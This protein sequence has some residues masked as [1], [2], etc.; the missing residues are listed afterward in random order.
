MHPRSKIR[1]LI[2]YVIVRA[3]DRCDVL[4]T[5]AMTSTDNC[6]TDHRLIRSIMSIHLMRKQRM[7]K[8]Q[9]RPKLNIEQ[10]GDITYQQ[11]LQAALS[12]DLPKQYP[13]DA[14]EHWDKLSSAIMDSSISIL[15]QKKRKHQDWYD[16][17]DTEIQQLIDIKRQT[18]ITWQNNINCKVKRAAH[19]KAKAAVQSTVRKLKNLWWMKKA[20]E[21]QQFVDSGDTRGFF[22]HKSGIRPQLLFSDIPLV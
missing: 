19:A 12:A 3:K 5:R 9:S 18:F 11:H 20:Q 7:Q 8:R 10:L 14:E 4:N 22:E 16:E 21:I 17:N 1:H 6:W 2:D 15:G 13:H